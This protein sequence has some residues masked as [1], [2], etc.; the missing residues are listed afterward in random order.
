[1]SSPRRV[2][3]GTALYG[4]A[5]VRIN[6][7]MSARSDLLTQSANFPH[8]LAKRPRK[9]S[10]SMEQICYSRSIVDLE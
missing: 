9:Q 4:N 8:S 2:E 3:V 10:S 6:L 7:H 5:P 1:M